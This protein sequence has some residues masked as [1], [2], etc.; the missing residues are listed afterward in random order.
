MNNE[1]EKIVWAVKF[2][3]F[4]MDSWKRLEN[5]QCVGYGNGKNPILFDSVG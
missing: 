3:K 2:K 5:Y 4:F 1:Y